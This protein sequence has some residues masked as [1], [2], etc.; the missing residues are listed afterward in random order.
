[1]LR[2]LDREA[3]LDRRRANALRL[4]DRALV[5]HD[6]ASGARVSRPER[7][8]TLTPDKTRCTTDARCARRNAEHA[9]AYRLCRKCGPP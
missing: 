4:V 9:P 5:E 2:L 7:S 6:A 3:D 1:L 8:A